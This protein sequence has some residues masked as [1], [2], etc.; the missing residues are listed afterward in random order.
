MKNF[1]KM[2]KFSESGKARFDKLLEAKKKKNAANKAYRQRK[3]KSPDNLL[4]KKRTNYQKQKDKIE[5]LEAH[6]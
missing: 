2:N 1:I 4:P 3:S 5:D 6:R